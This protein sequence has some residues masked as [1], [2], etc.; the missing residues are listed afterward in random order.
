M[1]EEKVKQRI[2][3]IYKKYLAL[4]TAARTDQEKEKLQKGFDLE[5]RRVR[6][7]A[8][9]Q[10]RRKEAGKTQEQLGASIGKSKSY[11]KQIEA[12]LISLHEKRETVDKLV[13]S[14]SGWSRR[15]AYITLG[16][17]YEPSAET[18]TVSKA[19]E[20]LGAALL[21]SGNVHQFILRAL[22]IRTKFEM[23]YRKG[24]PGDFL[25]SQQVRAIFFKLKDSSATEIAAAFVRIGI[26]ADL[27]Q[28]QW[29]RIFRSYKKAE[30][31]SSLEP[32][33]S[34]LRTIMWDEEQD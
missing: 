2:E 34:A 10:R 20:E 31:K 14:L 19:K 17:E 21:D 13:K 4:T 9:M 25:K 33:E 23:D 8:E 3:S 28:K 7:G 11:I 24:E 27:T 1:N 6:F 18:M 5:K 29:E 12:G 15:Q 32:L 22:H 30:G 26:N 16:I